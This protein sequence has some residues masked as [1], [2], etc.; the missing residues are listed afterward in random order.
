MR[1]RIGR[2]PATSAPKLAPAPYDRLVPTRVLRSRVS[3]AGTAQDLSA[4][5]PANAR[6]SGEKHGHFIHG[7]VE[8]GGSDEPI[9]IH[10]PAT[11]LRIAQCS[12]GG[13]AEIDA[14]VTAARAAFEGPWSK[15]TAAQRSMVLWKIAD[16]IQA[17]F[18]QLCELEILDNGLPTPLAQYVCGMVVPEFFA[19]TPAGQPKSKGPLYPPRR[20]ANS[21]VRRFLSRYA[22]PSESWEPSHLGTRRC[23]W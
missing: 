13:A 1:P 9:D 18:Q 22:S 8:H 15:F 3:H 16:L 17:N 21:R 6:V 20:R 10:D 2:T 23:R 14:A 4:T 7:R 19:T 12:A 5:L 11:G